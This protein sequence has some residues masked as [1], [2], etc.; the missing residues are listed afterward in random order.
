MRRLRS[1]RGVQSS[2]LGDNGLGSIR[3]KEKI[4]RYS[5]TKMPERVFLGDDWFRFVTTAD[6]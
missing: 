4:F 3:I 6:N 5:R 2:I 1:E